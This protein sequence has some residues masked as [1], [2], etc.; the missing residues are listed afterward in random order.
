MIYLGCTKIQIQN[1]YLW[2]ENEKP[3]DF[4]GKIIHLRDKHKSA[5]PPSRMLLFTILSSQQYLSVC[6][7]C[8]MM[9]SC[10]IKLPPPSPLSLPSPLEI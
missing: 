3:F 6:V 4:D 2:R 5:K 7:C 10:G 1:K 9:G 8:N